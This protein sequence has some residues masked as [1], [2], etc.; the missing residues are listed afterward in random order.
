LL[1]G[2]LGAFFFRILF[3]LL[4]ITLLQSFSWMYP[5]L[6]AILCFTAILAWK[7]GEVKLQDTFV[8]RGLKKVVHVEEGEHK[9]QFWI[10]K[11]GR[12]HATRLLFALLLI[13]LFDLVFAIDSIPA[14]LSITQDPFLAYTS[15]VFAVL[16]LRSFYLALSRWQEKMPDIKSAISCILLFVGAKMVS[17]PWIHIPNGISLT[18]VVVILVSFFFFAKKKKPV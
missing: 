9:G 11:K 18:V 16:G 17:S 7:S 1:L 15:N 14:V 2:I 4:G 12:W 3:I 10:K 13:E 8:F 6:G 5:V